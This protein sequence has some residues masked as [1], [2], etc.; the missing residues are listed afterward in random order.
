MY[1]SNTIV[2][3]NDAESNQNCSPVLVTSLGNNISDDDTCNLVDSTDQPGSNPQIGSLEDNGG[4][5]ATHALLLGSPAIDGGDG[6]RC[7]QAD[8]RGVVRPQRANC[9]IGAYEF[10]P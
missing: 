4:P 8:Q 10:A 9:D 6:S 2:S 7:T 1:L 5:T 3:G